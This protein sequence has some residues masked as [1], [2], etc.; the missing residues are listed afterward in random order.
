MQPL[1]VDLTVILTAHSE[2]IV[3][4]P[5]L[6]SAD[7]AI[8]QA[9]RA[10]YR[11]ERL[12]ALDMATPETRAFHNQPALDHWRKVDVDGGDLGLTRNAVL[13]LAAGQ[14]IALSGCR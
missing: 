5:T 14:N 10:G 1:P 2:T 6:R 13:P 7:A 9:E 4:G 8:A 3:S 11:I 12:V